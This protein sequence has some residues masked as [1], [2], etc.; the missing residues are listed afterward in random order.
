MTA[1][2]KPA[3]KAAAKKTAAKP[4]N[5]VPIDASEEE[6]AAARADTPNPELTDLDRDTDACRY[7]GRDAVREGMCEKH[8]ARRGV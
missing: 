4:A 1:A 7:C 8:A 2:K 3:K 5:V 6:K